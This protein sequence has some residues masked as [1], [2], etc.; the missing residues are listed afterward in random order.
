MEL[1]SDGTPVQHAHNGFLLNKKTG[2][3]NKFTPSPQTS[4]VKATKQQR[5]AKRQD[6]KYLRKMS[7]PTSDKLSSG[8]SYIFAVLGRVN[9]VSAA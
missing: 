5:K 6:R 2:L 8:Y 9:G 4:K 7:G 1:R 3:M